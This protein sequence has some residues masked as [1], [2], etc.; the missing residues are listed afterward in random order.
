MIKQCLNIYNLNYIAPDIMGNQKKYTAHALPV[1]SLCNPVRNVTLH[2]RVHS[3]I[4]KRRMGIELKVQ[5]W[6]EMKAIKMGAEVEGL[7]KKVDFK[8]KWGDS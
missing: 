6:R 2:T 1:R 3:W 8:E 7:I 5:E 4:P